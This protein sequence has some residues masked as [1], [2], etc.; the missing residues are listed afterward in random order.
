MHLVIFILIFM[1]FGCVMNLDIDDYL[2]VS[3]SINLIPVS[4]H[5]TKTTYIILKT[6]DQKNQHIENLKN[7][8]YEYYSYKKNIDEIQKSWEIV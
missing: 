3:G 8:F 4:L 7:D 5:N 6:V 2:E 1:F